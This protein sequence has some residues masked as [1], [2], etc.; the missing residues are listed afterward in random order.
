M[1]TDQI[2]VDVLS[3]DRTDCQHI[4]A[5]GNDSDN[6]VPLRINGGAEN[7]SKSGRGENIYTHT[8]TASDSVKFFRKFV[9]KE[10]DFVVSGVS[11]SSFTFVSLQTEVLAGIKVRECLDISK[12]VEG[13]PGGLGPASGHD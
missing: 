12:T 7:F 10:I 1:L 8:E 4:L 13:H 5:R 9:T 2:P 11:S 3:L 6:L